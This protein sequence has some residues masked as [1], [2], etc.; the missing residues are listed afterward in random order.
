MGRVDTLGAWFANGKG[1]LEILI[2]R[3]CLM[4]MA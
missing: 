3:Y 2:S 4:A 1:R